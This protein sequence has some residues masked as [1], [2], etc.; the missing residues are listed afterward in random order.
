MFG[1]STVDIMND[2]EMIT[3]CCCVCSC[4]F[5]MVSTIITNSYTDTRRYI[6]DSFAHACTILLCE[7][8]IIFKRN[9]FSAIRSVAMPFAIAVGSHQ[10]IP[11]LAFIWLSGDVDVNMLSVNALLAFC[12][13]LFF[14]CPF[15]CQ[16]ILSCL[17]STN[18]STHHRW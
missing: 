7:F 1:K 6:C 16:T 17:L 11:M 8:K 15:Y 9:F 18:G 12:F 4:V 5:V 10:Q 3:L 14:F 13:V 2:N